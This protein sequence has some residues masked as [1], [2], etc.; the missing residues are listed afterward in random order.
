MAEGAA[1]TSAELER[2]FAFIANGGMD[3]ARSRE[4]ERQREK[5]RRATE[6]AGRAARIAR[7]TCTESPQQ[8]L[9]VMP[10]VSH[11]LGTLHYWL[12]S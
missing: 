12:F 10:S 11:L 1:P 9:P 5:V 6:Q 2:V 4:V 7:Q 3:K 8:N